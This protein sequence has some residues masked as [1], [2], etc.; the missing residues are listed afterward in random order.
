MDVLLRYLRLVWSLLWSAGA[1]CKTNQTSR[2]FAEEVPIK[3][4][5]VISVFGAFFGQNWIQTELDKE[6]LCGAS[7][8]LCTNS[9]QPN[10]VQQILFET[11]A[12]LSW[13]RPAKKV[14]LDHL[15]SFLDVT[16]PI[17]TAVQIE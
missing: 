14:R 16:V 15:D 2:R 10:C 11:A 1:F 6:F 13:S 9:I 7:H 12:S 8:G 5:L 17:C 3:T 4:N